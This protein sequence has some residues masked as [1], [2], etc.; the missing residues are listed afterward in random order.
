MLPVKKSGRKPGSDACKSPEVKEFS[1]VVN[2]SLN[3]LKRTGEFSSEELVREAKK[4]LGTKDRKLQKD[5]DEHLTMK[6][7]SFRSKIAD[8]KKK[9]INLK[10]RTEDMTLTERSYHHSMKE[11]TKSE[12]LVTAEAFLK[13]QLSRV[14]FLQA[15]RNLEK[16]ENIGIIKKAC[17][18]LENEHNKKM[19]SFS[20]SQDS[21]LQYG[22]DYGDDGS[23]DADA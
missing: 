10:I 14:Y 12:D 4:V 5:L 6:E 20:D 7:T 3:S 22:S 2:S 11:D 13:Y 18:A 21:H 23:V 9:M 8:E 17:V 16:H 19:L 1:L 15:T